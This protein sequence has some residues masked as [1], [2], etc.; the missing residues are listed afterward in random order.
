MFGSQKIGGTQLIARTP[1][2]MIVY[3][4]CHLFTLPLHTPSSPD[5]Y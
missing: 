1:A 5:L 4:I 2:G 3:A